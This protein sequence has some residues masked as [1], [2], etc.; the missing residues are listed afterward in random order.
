M[1]SVSRLIDKTKIVFKYYHSV[2]IHVTETSNHYQVDY[3][4]TPA[5]RHQLWPRV[6]A[7]NVHLDVYK[8][9]V[10]FILLAMVSIQLLLLLEPKMLSND[11]S[12]D[13]TEESRYLAGECQQ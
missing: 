4:S 11:Q 5:L 8:G 3:Q 6:S 12:F 2:D 10:H 7:L 1:F 9:S 13:F